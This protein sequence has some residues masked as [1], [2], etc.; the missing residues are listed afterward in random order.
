MT[1]EVKN[2]EELVKDIESKVKGITDA[3]KVEVDKT[4]EK[5]HNELLEQGKASKETTDL[6]KKATEQLEELKTNKDEV[7]QKLI[8]I[9]QR[10]ASGYTPEGKKSIGTSFIE[11]QEFEQYKNGE[12]NR[13]TV[14]IKNTILTESGSPAGPDGVLVAPDYRGLMANPYRSLNVLDVIPMGRTNSDVVHIPKENSRTNSAAE[15]NQGATKP[16]SAITYT[17][18]ELSVR[19]IAHWLKVSVQALSDAPLLESHINGTL[20][21]GVRHRVQTQFISGNGTAPNLSG[22]TDSGNFTAFTPATGD[23]A[24]DSINKAKYSVIGSDFMASH[25]FMNPATFGA[26]ER[27]KVGSGRNDYAST[28]GVALAYINGMPYIWGLPVVLSNDVT[29]DKLLVLDV[30][31]MSG[32]T[33]EDVS[34]QMFEQD[35]TNVQQNLLTIRAEGRFTFGVF[36]PAAVYYGD[37][38]V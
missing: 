13:A 28:D 31:Q 8:D 38:T 33:R 29:A 24:T 18:Q 6:L 10:V 37:L 35:D 2:A 21:H 26:I 11:S 4:L 7:S 30:N 9:E 32:Y 25:V 34:V 12:I 16:E 23:T 14:K 5:Y 19:T 22:I 36:R 15:T 3:Q 17:S 27:V 20:L 1:V